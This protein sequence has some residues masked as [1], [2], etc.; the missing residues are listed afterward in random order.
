MSL[1]IIMSSFFLSLSSIISSSSSCP[2]HYPSSCRLSSYLCR[3]SFL[4]PLHAHVIIHHHVVFLLI[5]VV[6]HFFFLFIIMP[7]SLSIIM[8]SFFL[9]LSSIISSSSSSFRAS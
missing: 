7:M 8:S 1:S 9:S 3:P 6:H 4:P 2:C 5:F